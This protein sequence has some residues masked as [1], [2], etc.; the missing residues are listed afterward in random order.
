M[1]LRFGRLS[2]RFS[3]KWPTGT[4]NANGKQKRVPVLCFY[5]EWRAIGRAPCLCGAF[6]TKKLLVSQV[7]SGSQPDPRCTSCCFL[8]FNSAAC[9]PPEFLTTVQL[10]ARRTLCLKNSQFPKCRSPVCDREHLPRTQR[11]GI[12]SVR[13]P[14]RRAPLFAPPISTPLKGGRPERPGLL[15]LKLPS[16]L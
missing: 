13:S 6:H 14:P 2:N 10:G 8:Y 3:S 1:S 15:F 5:A 4:E 11:T 9:V 16:A 12:R 7:G